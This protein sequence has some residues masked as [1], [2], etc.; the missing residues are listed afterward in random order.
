MASLLCWASHKLQSKNPAGGFGGFA[1]VLVQ[2]INCKRNPSGS[3]GGFAVVLV[4]AINCKSEILEGFGGLAKCVVS[5]VV[6]EIQVGTSLTFVADLFF[7]TPPSGK[8]KKFL[9][10][11][12][13]T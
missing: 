8:F 11:L 12:K 2:A 5:A 6:V 7:Q 3:F 9:A 4:Q 13:R 1:V 10:E